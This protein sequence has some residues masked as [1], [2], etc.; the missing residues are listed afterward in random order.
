MSDDVKKRSDELLR[1]ARRLSQKAGDAS[2]QAE[3]AGASLLDRVKDNF[4]NTDGDDVKI[5]SEARKTLNDIGWLAGK[6]REAGRL[7]RNVREKYNNS[8]I[9]TFMDLGIRG[10]KAA[11]WVASPVVNTTAKY[12]RW[13]AYDKDEDGFFQ[14]NKKKA[15]QRLL[16]HVFAAVASYGAYWGLSRH[17]GQFLINDKDLAHSTD[18]IYQIAGCYKTHPEQKKCGEHDGMIVIM[19]PTAIPG[20]GIFSWDYD[21]DA[22][23]VP[24]MGECRFVTHGVY[25]RVP[26][27]PFFRGAIKPFVTEIGACQAITSDIDAIRANLPGAETEKEPAKVPYSATLPSSKVPRAP[28]P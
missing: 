11:M 4:T 18:D 23:R 10:A 13:N 15:A 1:Q 7:A 16:V 25:L 12:L 19:E 5:S 24:K 27:L 21:T 9:G 3:K 20:L 8:A 14:F 26:G 17:E 28:S 2:K 22:G 6:I